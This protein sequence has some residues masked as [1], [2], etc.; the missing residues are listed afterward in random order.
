MNEAPPHESQNHDARIWFSSHEVPPGPQEIA[1]V[2]VGSTPPGVFGLEAAVDRWDGT[3]WT[4]YGRLNLCTWV[5]PCTNAVVPLDSHERAPDEGVSPGEAIRFTTAG[6]NQGYYRISQTNPAGTASGV[7][8]VVDGAV[9]PPP[10]PAVDRPTL[11][12]SPAVLAAPNDAFRITPVSAQGE[13]ISLSDIG[14]AR[15]ERWSDGTWESGTE[16]TIAKSDGSAAHLSSPAALD[17]GTYRI[18]IETA[19][20]D[21]E[22]LF[23]I[24]RTLGKS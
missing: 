1:A 2:I 19:D 8:R 7:I 16:V 20:G 13:V 21:W 14:T 11:A 17:D 18:T 22:G 9:S 15:L 3:Q 5:M 10:L 23:A 6:L 24:D 4:P 12:I